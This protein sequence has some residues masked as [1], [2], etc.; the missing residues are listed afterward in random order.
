MENKKEEEGALKWSGNHP[1]GQLQYGDKPGMLPELGFWLKI[2]V[3][4]VIP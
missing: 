4:T 3:N 1:A 2:R